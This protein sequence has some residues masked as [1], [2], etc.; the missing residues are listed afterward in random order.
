MN[1]ASAQIAHA[2][3]IY[4]MSNHLLTHFSENHRSACSKSNLLLL[5]SSNFGRILHRF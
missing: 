4:Y 2:L 1:C 3:N 5:N